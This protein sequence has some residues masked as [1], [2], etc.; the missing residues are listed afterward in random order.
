MRRALLERFD[1]EIGGGVGPFAGKAWRI[2]CM[3]HTARPRNVAALLGALEQV[4]SLVS[5]RGLSKAVW[6]PGDVSATNVGRFMAEHGIADFDVAAG[7]QSI[8]EPEWFW[9]AVV[10]FLGLRSTRRTARCSTTPKASPGHVV[11]RRARSTSP[12]TCCVTTRPAPRSCGRARTATHRTWTYGE[13]RRAGRAALA[14]RLARDGVGEGRRGRRLH[15]DGAR[16]RRRAHRRSAARR[17]LPP[18]LLGLRRRRGRGRGCEDA[19][20]VALVT[21]DGTYRRGKAVDMA[22]V[23]DAA[24]ARC[25]TVQTVV[26][27]SI[28]LGRRSATGRPRVQLRTIV[29]RRREHPLFIAYTSGTTGRPKGAVHVHGGFLVKV[30]EEVAFQFDCRPDDTLF[31]FTDMGWIMGPWEVVGTPRQ[32]RDARALR[33]RARLARARP[34]LGVRRPP[35]T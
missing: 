29:P 6:F 15:A 32:R 21:A 35:P 18:A 20:A 8:A 22:A 33:G 1:I 2:G 26:D 25:P 10:R 5:E 7:A 27:P 4:L 3:G 28:G 9:D 19:G 34:A 11:Q 23:A 16:D 14:D 17:G 13:L 24:V 31:W 12:P 30:A